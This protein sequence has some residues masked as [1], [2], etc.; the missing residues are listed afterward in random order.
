[1]D[2]LTG[3]HDPL[4]YSYSELAG[5]FRRLYGK[6]S[7]CAGALFETVYRRGHTNV[8]GHPRYQANPALARRVARDFRLRLPRL[9]ALLEDGPVRKLRLRLADG[10]QIESVLLPMRNH[11]TLCL[12]SQAGCGRGC[13]FCETARLG[14]RRNLHAGE[15]VAQV[16]AARFLLSAPVTNLVFMGMGEPLD[17]LEEV[18]RAV[19]IAGDPRG[20][21]ISRSDIC[22]STCGQADGIRRLAR[23]AERDRERGGDLRALRLAVS[24]NAPNDAIRSS[25][26]PVN[27]QYPM[28]ALKEA[29]REWKR[30]CARDSLSVEY[31]L[32]AG[33]NDRREHAR[34]LAAWLRELDTAVHLIPCNPRRGAPFARPAPERVAEFFRWLAEEEGQ[35]CLVRAGRGERILAGCGQLGGGR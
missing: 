35:F 32:I 8:A 5:L 13:A 30:V 10:Q 3:S 9:S 1:M 12:S 31:V 7:G 18:L 25:L 11:L 17:N 21:A 24:L 4:R 19:R 20:L 29:L 23:L 33:V 28:E 6:G 14:L 27:R 26:M 16:M 15:I 34:Q 2:E 22:L